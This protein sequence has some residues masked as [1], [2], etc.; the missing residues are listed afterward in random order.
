MVIK[1]E[2]MREVSEECSVIASVDDEEA[3]LRLFKKTLHVALERQQKTFVGEIS[4]LRKE[5]VELRQVVYGGYNLEE[6]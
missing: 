5:V 2:R 6:E 3:L 4:K 1:E